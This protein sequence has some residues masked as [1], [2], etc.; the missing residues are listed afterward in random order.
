MTLVL[1]F[2]LGTGGA[3]A[4]VYD[5]ERRTMLATSEASYATAHPRAGWAEQQPEEWWAAVLAAGRDAIAQ[6]GSNDIAAVCVATTAS[7]VVICD[8][9]SAPLYPAILWMDCR[10]A[11]EAR[12]TEAVSHPVMAY[13]G[14]GDA[15]EWLVPKA[16]WLA[17]NEPEVFARADII[18]EALDFINCRLSGIWAGSRMNAACKWNY[19]S[20]AGSFV[21]E[22]Y[23]ALGIPGLHG[24]LPATIVPVG[25]PIGALLP[26]VRDAL[27]IAAPAIVVQGGIDAHIGMLGAG[28]VAA[29]GMLIIG[30]TS[31]V[32]LTHLAGQGDVRGFWGPY[33]NALVDGLWL[34]EA[35]QVS[36]GSILN[37]LSRKIFGLDEAG[38]ADLIREASSA[39]ARNSGLLTLD[40]WMGNRTPY[41]DADLRGAILGL[42]LGHGRADIYSA[43]VDSIA[44]G[45]ANVVDVLEERS[46]SVDRI[47]VAGGICKNPLWLQATVD[48]L[49]RPVQVAYGDNLSLIGTAACSAHALGLFPD[50][51]SASE[52]CAAPT[53][54]L[55]PDPAASRRYR[56]MLE[57]YRTATESL[58][59][60][61]HDLSARQR[62]GTEQ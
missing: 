23:E 54:E 14:G 28:T 30:G 19:D 31:V 60:V 59:P 47:V 35:G 21:P 12:A 57:L 32:H 17:A 24:K 16:M 50:L 34:V 5:V 58:T 26:E 2:D 49:G 8:K 13:S 39:A 42:S 38:H 22:I 41:R 7:S 29:G 61:L 6:C 43:A 33:P 51:I 45:S 62:A 56:N 15:A 53:R 46:V 1:S 10:A 9:T 4:G 18:C 52:S 25:D 37:W 40:Y 11:A 20:S 27:G 55:L 48:A 44:L 36:A 3:R